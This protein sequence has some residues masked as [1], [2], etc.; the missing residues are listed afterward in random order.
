MTK[1]TSYLRPGHHS[2]TPHLV[3]RG[4]TEA[5]AFY[6]KVFGAQEVARSPAPDGKRLIHATMRIGDSML[7]L[8]DEFPE[9]GSCGAAAGTG[10]SISLCLYVEDA[11]A[12]YERAVAAGSQ[13]K[14]PPADMFWGDRYSQIIDPFGQEWAIATHKEDLTPQEMQQRQ[15]AFFQTMS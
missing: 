8:C 2:I 9:W 5:I 15:Q 7:M 13:P 6:K 1:A 4:G 14:M 10:R 3:V 11:D 12:V